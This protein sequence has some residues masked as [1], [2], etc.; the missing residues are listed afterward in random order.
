[1]PAIRKY[2]LSLILIL[3]AALTGMSQK[4]DTAILL[5]PDQ[6]FDGERM[7]RKT[8]FVMK[9]GIIYVISNH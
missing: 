2:V 8:V 7:H 3:S 6:V 4:T 5:K 9:D 1:M